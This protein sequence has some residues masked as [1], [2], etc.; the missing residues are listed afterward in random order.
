MK[1]LSW[2]KVGCLLLALLMAA[3]MLAT[4]V[5]ATYDNVYNSDSLPE[6]GSI[7]IT[8]LDRD[9]NSGYPDPALKNDG[10]KV[11]DIA[12]AGKGLNGVT[13]TIYKV[14]PNYT[15]PEN[16]DVSNVAIDANKVAEGTTATVDGQDGVLVFDKLEMYQRYLIVET[17]APAYVTTSTAPFCVDLPMTNPMGD[18]WMADVYVYP[19]NYTT[20]GTVTLNKV[21]EDKEALSGAIFG[22]YQATKTDDEYALVTQDGNPVLVTEAVIPA[23]LST[24]AT[25]T[26]NAYAMSDA[27][28]LVKFT[29]IPVGDYAL[30]EVKAPT[31]HALD[32]TPHFF[33][34]VK[35]S[36]TDAV[37]NV[38]NVVNY[39]TLSDD[40]IAKSVKTEGATGVNWT[41]TTDLPANIATYQKYEIVDPVPNQVTLASNSIAVKATKESAEALTLTKG[42]DY[43]LTIDS[44]NTNK[45]TVALTAAGM[46][47][48]ASYEALEITFSSTINE[49]AVLGQVTN[50]GNA[51]RNR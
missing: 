5:V 50:T 31:G 17:D 22:L 11:E 10:T 32:K 42:E 34:I 16:G 47:K 27:S 48:V 4:G 21:G 29:N 26:G 9:E 40:A 14:D 6:T 2:K 18:G 41:V 43:T 20:R 38:G 13:F 28:G 19:K 7:K 45:F 3:T 37:V 30:I 23:T 1:K 49:G 35:G 33:S 44:A 46:E 12:T 25:Y 24:D 36:Q 39:E 51:Q 8:K 15:V